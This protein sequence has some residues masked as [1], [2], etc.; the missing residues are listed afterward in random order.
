MENS[1]PVATLSREE[2]IK[3]LSENGINSLVSNAMN[4][5]I[6]KFNDTKDLNEA[7]RKMVET[8]NTMAL[9]LNQE[10]FYGIVDSENILEYKM[11][12]SAL[13]K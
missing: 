8:N 6:L 4:L 13:G 12:K 10:K 7:Y 9:V 3:S 1:V 5:N 11:V 2:M